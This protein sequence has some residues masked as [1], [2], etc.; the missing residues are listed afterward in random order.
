MLKNLPGKIYFYGD[1]EFQSNNNKAN[2]AIANYQTKFDWVLMAA[3]ANKQ[4]SLGKLRCVMNRNIRNIPFFGLLFK[5]RQFIFESSNKCK[6]PNFTCML[7]HLKK[8]DFPIWF[9]IFPENKRF[10]NKTKQIISLNTKF[11]IEHQLPVFSHV[12]LPKIDVTHAALCSFIDRLY[13]FN[14]YTIAYT[15]S[16]NRNTRSSIKAPSLNQIFEDDSLE[17]HILMKCFSKE[18]LMK[19][20]R[21]TETVDIKLRDNVFEFL[22]NIFHQKDKKLNNFFSNPPEYLVNSSESNLQ[23]FNLKFKNVMPGF[24]LFSLT[25]LFVIY[26]NYF[27]NNR[28]LIL[29]VYLIGAFISFIRV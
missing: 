2:I 24:M 14:D 20:L 1:L 16:S 26:F 25:N 29:K 9:L 23:M 21:A 13:S 18:K 11:A 22:I 3:V 5:L 12:L 10:S 8:L 27:S 4:N 15:R 19:N 7:E 17:I 28:K 6:E